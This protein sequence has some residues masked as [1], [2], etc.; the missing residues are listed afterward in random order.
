MIDT[1]MTL[2]DRYNAVCQRVADAASRAGRDP[3]D[4]ITVAVTKY[5]E[6]DQVRE[7]VELGHRDFGEN[8]VPQLVQRA[9]MIEEYIRRRAALG[10]NSSGSARWHM[11]GHLQ[12]NKARKLADCARLVHSVDSLRLAEELQA[13][14]LKYE[15]P[16]DVLVQINISGEE[17]KYGC[18]LPACEPLAEAMD[19]MAHLRVRG[20]MTMAPYTDNPEDSRIHFSRLRELFEDLAQTGFGEGHFNILS[21]G[22]SNDFEVAIEEGANVIRVGSAI[23]GERSET[24]E[25]EID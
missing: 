15:R 5:A 7:L 3:N 18:P 24:D 10:H 20:L 23:F 9:A 6:M 2:A 25:P 19:S 22:M 13:V 21:M 12:R 4:I 14:G 1:A 16:V 11:I 17:S 8:R